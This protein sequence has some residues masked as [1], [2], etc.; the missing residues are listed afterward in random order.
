MAGVM[1]SVA[2]ALDVES[3]AGC[4][5]GDPLALPERRPVARRRLRPRAAGGRAPRR[6]A[7]ARRA[8]AANPFFALEPPPL[9]FVAW[10]VAWIALV[11]GLAGWRLSRRDL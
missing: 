3:L 4:R 6:W 7:A 2:A 5:R 1:A 9:A 8:L 11:L 10:S